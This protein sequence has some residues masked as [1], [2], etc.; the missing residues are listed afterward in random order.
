MYQ[1]RLYLKM[2]LTSR[3]HRHYRETGNAMEDRARLEMYMTINLVRVSLERFMRGK[4]QLSVMIGRPRLH[5]VLELDSSS[6]PS[7]INVL[8]LDVAKVT[9]RSLHLVVSSSFLSSQE[10]LWCEYN[11]VKFHQWN[12]VQHKTRLGDPSSAYNVHCLRSCLGYTYRTWSV[13][14]GF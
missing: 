6:K 14:V 1:E 8:D 3:R 13:Q 10:I 9:L 5:G 7:F 12:V 11:V 4:S 2:E